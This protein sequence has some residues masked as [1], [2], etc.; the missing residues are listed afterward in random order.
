MFQTPDEILD[1]ARAHFRARVIQ[2][3]LAVEGAGRL[4]QP[5]ARSLFVAVVQLGRQAEQPREAQQPVAVAGIPA[6]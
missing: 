6:F 1:L 4:A 2:R 5:N 3:R